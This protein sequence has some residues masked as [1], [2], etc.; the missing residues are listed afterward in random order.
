M[1]FC[2]RLGGSH[3]RGLTAVLDGAQHRV[4]RHH[5]LA[6]TDLAHQEALHRVRGLQVRGDLRNRPP[7]IAGQREREPMLQPALGE[8]RLL[9]ERRRARACLPARAAAQQQ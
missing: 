9:G 4:Q 3:Q 8:R 1:L 2:E 7:L 5:R 6:A